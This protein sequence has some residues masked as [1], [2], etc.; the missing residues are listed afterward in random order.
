MRPGKERQIGAGVRLRVGIEEMVR[1]RVVLVDGPFD[2]PHP[3]HN[4]VERQIHLRIARD[5]RDVM[6]ALISVIAPAAGN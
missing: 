2:E 1:A 6:D 4:R 5:A 3:Q